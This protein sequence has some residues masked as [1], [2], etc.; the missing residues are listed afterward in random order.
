MAFRP[1]TLRDIAAD[2]PN[3]PQCGSAPYLPRS[4]DPN[5]GPIRCTDCGDDVGAVYQALSG[6]HGVY[7][8]PW[9]LVLML[10]GAALALIGAVATIIVT[11]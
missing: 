1:P 4:A 3:C 8:S 10:A 6:V 9:M 2:F 11:P 7:G 5:V